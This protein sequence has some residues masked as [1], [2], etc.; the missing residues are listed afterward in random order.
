MCAASIQHS[1]NAA[2]N[3][4]MR[5]IGGPSA[6]TQFLRSIGDTAFRLD[7]WEPDLNT[8]IP[9][10]LPGEQQDTSTPGGVAQSLQH[11]L[12]D[13]D[14]L[15]QTERTQLIDWLKGNTTGDTRIRAS[16]PQGGLSEIK[17]LCLFISG[18]D[19]C[20]FIL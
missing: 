12:V 20:Q 18:R 19:C 6:V 17:Q 2:A 14:A 10:E 3:L 5:K 9:G 11:L 8:P 15:G 4:L 16:V 7:R 1:D 13:G